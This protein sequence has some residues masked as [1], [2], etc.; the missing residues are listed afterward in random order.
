[1]KTLKTVSAWCALILTCIPRLKSETAFLDGPNAYLGQKPPSEIPKVFA[2]GLLADPGTFAIGRIGMSPDGKQILYTQNDTWFNSTNEQIKEFRF[3]DGRWLGPKVLF[4]RL[5][6]PALSADGKVLYLGGSMTQVLRCRRTG[7]S[8]GAPEPFFESSSVEVYN[9]NPT[10]SSH[11]YACSNADDEDKRYGS[12]DVFSLVSLDRGR[13][14]ARSLGRPLN[15]I[16]FNGDF[17][18][19]PD[20]SFIVLSAKE[21]TD[22]EC[23][24]FISYRKA[25]GSW[26]NPKSLGAEINNGVAH[27]FGE[28]V[29][30]D[31]KYLFYTKGTSPKDTKI[32][33]VRFDDM[34]ERLRYTHFDPYLK[35]Q[36]D[37]Q[38]AVLGKAFEFTVPAETFV[39]DNRND[40]LSLG[41]A[42]SDVSQLPEWLKFNPSTRSFSGIPTK[43][44]TSKVMISAKDT[45]GA[46]V[47]CVFAIVT[48]AN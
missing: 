14:V 44:G 3:Q 35:K 1:V 17:F 40:T 27:R 36:I 10:A 47:S 34:L 11:F 22:Y 6:N 43:A 12:T 42:A 25:D 39:D 8:W 30:P 24:I 48:D 18:V 26:T 7:G 37:V 38:N 2:A 46:S 4:H 41:A 33:W 5:A 19:S 31:N 9:F 28:Y 29:T 15:G 16:G 23:E 20:E 21:T 45:S 13:P 32:Y